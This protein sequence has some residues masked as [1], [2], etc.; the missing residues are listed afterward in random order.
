MG[1]DITACSRIRAAAANEDDDSVSMLTVSKGA[2]VQGA[3][4]K[5]GDR[6]VTYGD[7]VHFRAGSYSGY[8]RWREWLARSAG[9][10]PEAI[11]SEG[12]TT[13]N[14]LDLLINFSDCDGTFGSAAAHRV[15][16]ALA[17][18]RVAF[19]RWAKENL[20]ADEVDYALSRY[21]LWTAAMRTAAQG[22]VLIFH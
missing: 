14:D 22:G 11:W 19:E 2:E 9:T 18:H 3:P 5:D 13:G 15:A 21:D 17:A 4:W 16:L 10:T 1:L 8:N 7:E 6:V 12:G 20:L